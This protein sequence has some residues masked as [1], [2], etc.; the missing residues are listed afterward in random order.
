MPR[1]LTFLWW[2][3]PAMWSLR[4][5]Y[6]WAPKKSLLLPYFR[7][8]PSL[9]KLDTFRGRLMQTCSYGG[10]CWNPMFIYIQFPTE[11]QSSP[12]KQVEHETQRVF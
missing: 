4:Q 3:S 9:S 6:S 12:D 11:T 1:F 2:F 8:R 7:N 10:V 5:L